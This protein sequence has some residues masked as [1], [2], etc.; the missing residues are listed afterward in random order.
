MF[1]CIGGAWAEVNDA[2]KLALVFLCGSVAIAQP[3]TISARAGTINYQ[4]GAIYVDDQL[5]YATY[6][7]HPPFQMKNGQRLRI[8][9]GTVELLLGAGVYLR[10]LGPSA[11]RM[12][13]TQ[14]ADARVVVENGSALIEV[15][16]MN[17]DA[18]LRVI[19]GE[20]STE[21]KRDGSYRFDAPAEAMAGK[22]RIFNGEAT[23]M[24]NGIAVKGRTGL[25]IDLAAGLQSSKFDLRAGDALQAWAV[26]R[27]QRRTDYERRQAEARAMRAAKRKAQI[28]T[29]MN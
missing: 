28:E 13:Q 29:Q 15:A 6:G 1:T 7:D 27:S 22:L 3:R 4:R 17:P 20:S 8:E 11:I 5:V 18:R 10:M 19:C 14:L 12:Q 2:G 25:A 21:I 9:N 26:R 23:V 24:R 16:G